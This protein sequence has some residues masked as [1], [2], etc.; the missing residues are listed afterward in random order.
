MSHVTHMHESCHTYGRQSALQCRVY[1][2]MLECIAVCSVLQCVGVC[3]S[4]MSHIWMTG[5]IAVWRVLQCAGVYGSVQCITVCWSVPQCH[6]THMDDSVYCSVEGIV[7]CWSVWQC[8]VYC[9]V[10]ECAAVHVIHM[11]D[12]KRLR[13]CTCAMFFYLNTVF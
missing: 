12:I 2:S 4:A 10:L 13:F 3:R 6:V 7:V 11:D 8:A 9:S 5:C 1:C